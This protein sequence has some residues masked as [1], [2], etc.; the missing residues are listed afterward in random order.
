M[1]VRIPSRGRRTSQDRAGARRESP[2]PAGAVGGLAGRMLVVLSLIACSGGGTE[3]TAPP[4]TAPTASNGQGPLPEPRMGVAEVST[5]PELV[6]A[7]EVQDRAAP[8]RLDV[9]FDPDVTTFDELGRKLEAWGFSVLDGDGESWRVG[10]PLGH[11]WPARLLPLAEVAD[12]TEAVDLTSLETGALR[13]GSE[14]YGDRVHTWSW[15][16]GGPVQ[17]VSGGAAPP[18]PMLPHA[19]PASVVRCL[20]P[21]RTAMGTGVSVGV[22]WERALVPEPLSW[23]VVVE[24]YGACKASGWFALRSDAP[25]DALRIDGRPVAEVEP[26]VVYGAAVEYLATVRPYDDPSAIAAYDLL[27]QAPTERLAAALDGLAPGTFQERLWEELD[28][29]DPDNALLLAE[30]ATSPT[31]RAGVT[32]EV[33]SLRTA[34]LTD[35]K[36]PADAVFAALTVWRPDPGDTSGTLE[37][38]RTHPSPRVRE[39]AWEITIETTAAACEARVAGIPTASV[40]TVSALYRECPQQTVRVAAFNHL[41]KA[42][43][44]AAGAVLRVVLEE[45]ETVRTGVLAARHAAALERYDLLETLIPRT[46]VS[47]DVRRVGLELLVK[48]SKSA[49]AEELVEQH[50]TYLGYRPGPTA[51]PPADATADGAP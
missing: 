40:T 26:G 47:R 51:A 10:A 8:P 36:A 3:P 44:V 24:N 18:D 15:R 50:G 29:R 45:P 46:S 34:A 39:R 31:L 13:E 14:H 28:Q 16:E 17:S 33:E 2:R 11:E 1:S 25:V 27:R 12:V 42:D 49:L 38:L 4:P 41:A 6:R 5:P 32:A 35:P 19:L 9:R 30:K 22:G 7:T 43:P 20:A 37:R 21:L 48:G 23:A